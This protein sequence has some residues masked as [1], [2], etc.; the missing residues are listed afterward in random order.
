MLASG[1]PRLGEEEPEVSVE[2][3]FGAY[4]HALETELGIVVF[5]EKSWRRKI[6]ANCVGMDSGDDL[7]NYEA[8]DAFESYWKRTRRRT[9]CGAFSMEAA[10]HLR[11]CVRWS[12]G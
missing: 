6:W 8:D 2:S 12:C 1:K 10:T 11:R 7:M 4:I 5:D 9:T 3:N